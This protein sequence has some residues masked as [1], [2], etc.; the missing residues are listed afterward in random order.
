MVG[1]GRSTNEHCV[2]SPP[3]KGHNPVE[4]GRTHRRKAVCVQGCICH[5]FPIVLKRFGGGRYAFVSF[6]V[7]NRKQYPYLKAQ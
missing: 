1:I 2:R 3:V 6:I 7:L 4:Y 5:G